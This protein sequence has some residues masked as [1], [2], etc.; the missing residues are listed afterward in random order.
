MIPEKNM[1][2]RTSL[3]RRAAV[4]CLGMLL[5]GMLCTGCG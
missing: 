3:P 2:I 5:C 1:K 4:L